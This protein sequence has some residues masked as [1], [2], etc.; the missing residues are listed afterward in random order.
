MAPDR[1]RISVAFDGRTLTLSSLAKVM[2]P[3]TGTTKGEVIDYYVRVAPALLAQM[4]GRP[5]TRVRFPHGSGGTS[6]FEKN[7]PAGLPDWI[8]TVTLPADGVFGSE[9]TK[10]RW[11]IID[12][13]AALVWAVNLGSIE[14]HTPQWRMVRTADGGWRPGD[15]DRLVIDLDPGPGVGLS[16]CSV[17]A[18]RIRDRLR[19]IGVEPRPVTSGSKGLHVY[20]GLPGGF[21]AVM[22]SGIARD[23]AKAVTAEL[24]DLVVWQMAKDKRVGKVF[25]D[26]SQN[27]SAKTTVTP[28]SLRGRARPTVAAPRTWA[29]IEGAA[30]GADLRQLEPAE[31][32]GRLERDGDLLGKH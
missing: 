8:E 3:E 22:T 24:P 5:V 4:R 7:A 27:A 1:E 9:S 30:Q 23:L 21:D 26:W 2:Y 13:V 10:V 28:Y 6:F 31:V 29:E 18:L 16:E 20:A 19:A 17:V 25:V 14:V 15:P 12:N 11:P 32:L